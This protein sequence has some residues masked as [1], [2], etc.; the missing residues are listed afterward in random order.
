MRLILRTLFDGSLESMG[1]VR[2][3]EAVEALEAITGY[4]VLIY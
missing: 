3:V 1:A 2:A 4:N